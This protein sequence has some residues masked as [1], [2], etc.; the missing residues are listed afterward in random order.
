[1]REVTEERLAQHHLQ[2]RPEVEATARVETVGMGQLAAQGT[3]E[4]VSPY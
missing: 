2:R 1:M 3:T 4:E